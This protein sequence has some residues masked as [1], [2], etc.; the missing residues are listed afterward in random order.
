MHTSDER[1]KAETVDKDVVH[2]LRAREQLRDHVQV[3]TNLA[4]LVQH[5]L[6]TQT[7]D[8]RQFDAAAP[9]ELV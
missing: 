6:N 1:V 3:R 4:C 5:I 9:A 7:H 2:V 8:S